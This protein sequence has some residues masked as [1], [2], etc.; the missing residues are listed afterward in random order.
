MNQTSGR[1]PARFAAVG[2]NSIRHP[3]GLRTM[4]NNMS[5]THP[6][7]VF[8]MRQ[9]HLRNTVTSMSW[10][11]GLLAALVLS[12]TLSACGSLGR[13]MEAK[14]RLAKAQAMFAERC[15]TA[16]EKIQ[17]RVENVEGVL[18]LKV[19]P[20]KEDDYS[21]FDL[22]DPYGHDLGGRATLVRSFVA[23]TQRPTGTHPAHGLHHSL[24][25]TAMSKRSIRPT[26]YGIGI[27]EAS[28]RSR[29]SPASSS[30]EQESPLRPN[31]LFWT[32]FP[33]LVLLHGMA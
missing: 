10:R 9:E 33:P 2:G 22:I 25:A 13:A 28:E 31:L 7:E 23:N 27:Q 17:R 15:K 26:V 18:L 6:S 20:E 5:T 29:R 19:R 11:F 24:L 1:P 3:A 30:A 14:E 32:R 4:T 8:R 12:C 21:Q 16:G